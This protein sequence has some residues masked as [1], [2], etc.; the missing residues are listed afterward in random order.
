MNSRFIRVVLLVAALAPCGCVLNP[1]TGERQLALVSEAQ[2]IRMGRETDPQIAASLGVYDDPELQA[3]VQRLGETLA[4]LSERPNLPWTFRVVDDSVVNAFAVPGGFIYVTRGILAHLNSEAQLASVLGHEIG[5]VTARHSVEQTSRAQLAQLGLGVS[6]IL[7]PQLEGLTQMAGAGVGILFLRYGRDDELQADELGL[8][9]LLR[10]RYDPRPMPEVFSLLARVTS[11]EGGGQVPEW[12]STHPNPVNRRERIQ[13]ALK[14]ESGSYGGREVGGE[15]YLAHLGGLLFG[16]NPREGFFES[17]LFM[18]PNLAFQVAFPPGWR[19]SNQ[20]HV[21]VAASADDAAMVQL[22]VLPS[23]S[24]DSAARAFFAKE[25]IRGGPPRPNQING[26]Q[27][28]TGEF[29]AS[30]QRG[31]LE[32]AV[33]FVAHNGPVYRLLAFGAADKWSAHAPSASDALNSFAR[34][35]DREAL[36]VQPLRL[37]LV[38]LDRAMTLEQFSRRYPS[39][40]SLQE[41][42]LINQV[43]PGTPLPAG[44]SV[45]RVVQR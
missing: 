14:A 16:E 40:L 33:T 27:A 19:T 17:N 42:A 36:S 2:E 22:S 15:P 38:R 7:A 18:H 11:V 31:E 41:L 12:L 21:V 1:A 5:H 28:A 10:S 43:D 29:Q 39:V 45:K 9:Y 30:S 32:G 8:R 24:P 34:L 13:A 20:K 25:G 26:L 37:E 6:E 23:G 4:A 3:Y 35:T 44:S